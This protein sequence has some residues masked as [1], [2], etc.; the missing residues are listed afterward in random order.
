VTLGDER[1]LTQFSAELRERFP[2]Q[3][4]GFDSFEEEVA[5]WDA[6]F[7]RARGMAHYEERRLRE[8]RERTARRQIGHL[9]AATVVR[10]VDLADGL[11]GLINAQRAHAAFAV[12]RAV[13]ETAAVP[14]YVSKNVVPLLAKGRKERVDE[15]LRRLTVGLDPGLKFKDRPL[16][17]EP[18]RVS[19]L[20]KALC[21]EMDTRF[22]EEPRAGEETAGEMMLRLYSLVSDHTHPNHSAVHLSAKLDE[23]GID[24]DRFAPWSAGTLFDIEGP[25]VLAMWGGRVALKAVMDAANRHPLVLETK[26]GP[27]P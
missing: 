26:T 8:T 9:A 21:S 7:R 18:I 25:A 5:G 3:H 20:I 1:S 14:A 6:L 2:D 22:G 23:S 27:Y 13:I 17:T 19:S 24:W 4:A 15:A 10:V 12:T 16:D 11:V